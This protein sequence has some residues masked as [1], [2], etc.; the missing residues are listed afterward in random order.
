[1]IDGL[2][3]VDKPAGWTSHDV[4][5]KLRRLSGQRRIGHAG[6]LDPAATGVL[7]LGLGQA[8]RLLEYLS[9]ADK[10]YRSEFLL[11]VATDTDDA[12]GQVI[13]VADTAWL[14]AEQ[15]RSALAGFVGQIEQTPPQVSAV[16]VGG[17][18]A[19]AAVRA[20]RAVAIPPRTV[21]IHA[22]EVEAIALPRLTVVVHCGSGVY[23]RSL[24][25]DL[26]AR[27]GVGGHVARLRRLAV[28]GL[29]IETAVTL[30]EVAAAAAGGRLGELVLPSRAALGGWPEITLSPA[31]E[32]R[33]R[34]GQPLPQR[35][36]A[37]GRVAASDA[38]GR[39]IAILESVNGRWQPVKVLPREEDR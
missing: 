16:H 27:L 37:I 30:E 17:Q 21:T 6:T 38:A 18:R 35:D 39:L 20:G 13:G 7:V 23:I 9:N 12:D 14:T 10:V 29:R 8:T 26:G 5:A 34:E 33:V 2:L 24:A 36:P 28:G 19:Y 1:V 11:G 4:I 25:R 31:E 3:V 15:V 22:I 32:A